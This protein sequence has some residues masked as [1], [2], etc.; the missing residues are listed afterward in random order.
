[1]VGSATLD[2]IERVSRS[3]V[4]ISTL[5]QI[6][7]VFF[8]PIPLKGMGSGVVI[9]SSGYILTNNHVVQGADKITVTFHDGRVMEGRVVGTCPSFDVAVIKVEAENLEAVEIGDSD[10]LRVGQPVFAVG[11]PFGLAGGPTV[12]SG[13]VSA[14]G[15][16]IQAERGTLDNLIQT[17]A[18]INPGNSGGPLV[19]ENGKVI[20]ISTAI[21]PF[22]QG[23]G[24]AIPIKVAIRCADDIIR[25]GR[26]RIPWLGIDGVSINEAVAY[27]YNIP[28]AVGVLVVRVVEG[29]PAD[30]AGISPGD[31]ILEFGKKPVRTIEELRRKIMSSNVGDEAQIKIIRDGQSHQ[32][33]ITLGAMP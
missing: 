11:N 19:D 28:S 24:F 21:I 25:Y 26:V 10:K 32:V 14:L 9:R 4:N 17:D 7:D 13:V 3:V 22:A 23:I 15:R 30:V 6:R 29:S 27:R 1:M 5:S 33:K 8:R 20:A 31:V 18:A 2:A 12:T 16:T